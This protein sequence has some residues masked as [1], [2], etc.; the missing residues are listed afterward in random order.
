M[1][2]LTIRFDEDMPPAAVEIVSPDLQTVAIV[3]LS[4]G[5]EAKVEAPS[6]RSFL[7]VH[8]PSGKTVNLTH[9]R[10]MLNRSVSLATLDAA[11]G[12]RQRGSRPTVLP[13]AIGGPPLEGPQP[14]ATSLNDVR[15]YHVTR[16]QYRGF[17]PPEDMEVGEWVQF[18]PDTEARILSPFGSLK[19]KLNTRRNEATW[20]LM[21]GD[22]ALAASCLEIMHP[23]GKFF[24]LIPGNTQAVYARA[25]QIQESE[26]LLIGVRLASKEPAADTILNYLQ[27]G[28]LYAAGAMVDWARE[29]EQMLAGKVSDPYSAAVGAYLLLKLKRF[30]QMH[31]WVRNLANWFDFLPDGCVIWAWQQI[32]QNPSNESEIRDYLLRAASRGQLGYAG[33]PVYS[34]GLRLLMDGLSMLPDA[35]E[36]QAVREKVSRS[37]GTVLWGSPVTAGTRLDRTSYTRSS[38]VTYD[39]RFMAP[40]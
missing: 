19:G 36:A 38:P 7:C 10:G 3:M 24:A 32:H 23:W 26:S 14:I 35:S 6:E 30:E 25:D 1:S 16:A 33:L 22:A 31:T 9:E 34:Q 20:E 21:F 5:E 37:A 11:Q 40:A 17:A 28:D 12:I 13:E 27:Q 8:L 15:Q 18:A 2:E 39:V 4:G 29:A